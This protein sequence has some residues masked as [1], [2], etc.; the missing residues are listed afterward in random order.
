MNYKEKYEQWLNIPKM[1][2]ALK[3]ELINMNDKQKQ[4]AFTND[5]E[6]GTG[7]LR[8]IL[9]AGTNRLNVYIIRKATYGFGLYLKTKSNN[10]SAVIAYDNRNFSKEFALETAKVFASMNIKAYVAEEL[11]PTPYLSYAVR[12]LQATGG[13]MITAS[14]NTKEYNGY[15]IY[16]ADGCQL[17]PKYADIV[18]ENINSII[19]P[20]QIETEKNSDLINKIPA[21]IDKKYKAMVKEIS[22]RNDKKVLKVVYTPLHGTGSVF[23]PEIL[24]EL[25][26]DVTCVKEQMFHDPNFGSVTSA[27]PEERTAFDKA[28]ALGKEVRADLLLANDPD[29]D[30]LGIAPLHKGEYVLLNGNQTAS[31]ILDYLIKNTEKMPENPY[32]FSTIVS[33][34]L[35]IKMAIKNNINYKLVLT[36]FKFIG[37]QAKLLEGKG[38]YFFGYEESYG[39]L[40]SDKVR[41]KDAM[42]ASLMACEVANYYK[43]QGKTLVDVLEDIYQEYGYHLEG[44]KNISLKGLEGA[45]KIQQIMDYFR[46]NEID[47]PNILYKEDYQTGIVTGEDRK[48]DLPKSNVIRYVLDDD[49]WFILRPSG[50]EPKLKI[51]YGACSNTKAKAQEKLDELAN[52]V[53]A[54]VNNI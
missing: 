20:F 18:I 53:L 49:S 44:I 47:M 37:E 24:E 34:N 40:V 54:I 11:R 50:T 6:F 42:Q 22:L 16:D 31:I 51:Y 7:G 14:H 12:E 32:V 2:K 25:G 48:I 46:Q 4:E 45:K 21:S 19:N 29:A 27:N 13:V 39:C 33:S 3:D 28:I 8:G 23:A 17:V 43:L 41:D 30:R 36:G 52:K 38:T 35:P 5:I 15:K 10:P 26:Y 9:G 1:D